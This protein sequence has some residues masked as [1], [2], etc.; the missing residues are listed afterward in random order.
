[1]KPT[2]KIKIWLFLII[3]AIFVFIYVNDKR[4]KNPLSDAPKA[5][6]PQ[7]TQD[8]IMKIALI[9]AI[10][11]AIIATMEIFDIAASKRE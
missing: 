9:P 5:F 6:V 11:Y 4:L 10:L 8:S 1:M 7:E 2:T 3:A